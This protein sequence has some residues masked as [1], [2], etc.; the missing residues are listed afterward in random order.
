MTPPASLL[1]TTSGETIFSTTG[2]PIRAAASAAS[3]R[4]VASPEAGTGTPASR[5]SLVRVLLFQQR[6]CHDLPPAH[7]ESPLGG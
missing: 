5:S 6:L 2:N 4:V 3:S 7:S 1:W